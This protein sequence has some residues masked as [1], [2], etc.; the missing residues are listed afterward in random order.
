MDN[1]IDKK[2]NISSS[3]KKINR[4]IELKNTISKSENFK[5][6]LNIEIDSNNLNN[7]F[8]NWIKI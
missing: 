7:S 3:P 4:S 2:N 5:D 8:K 6:I 1:T